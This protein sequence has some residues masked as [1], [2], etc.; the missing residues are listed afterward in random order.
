MRATSAHPRR[1]FL[2]FPIFIFVIESRVVLG[3]VTPCTIA[4]LLFLLRC[5]FSLNINQRSRSSHK[6]PLE[7]V[8]KP[9][10]PV[11]ELQMFA[12]PYVNESLV[13]SWYLD[14][15]IHR[16]RFF[17]F[18]RTCRS[19]FFQI[20]VILYSVISEAPSPIWFAFFS[21]KAYSPVVQNIPIRNTLSYFLVWH[22]SGM[23]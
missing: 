22:K 21:F 3:C 4:V 19:S 10:Q 16:L 18:D 12:W 1:R 23:F 11:R 14:S 9:G 2:A 13:A 20:G 17:P 7:R 5:F 15:R 8:L 6:L